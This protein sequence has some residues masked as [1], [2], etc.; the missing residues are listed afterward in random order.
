MQL[1]LA[2]DV[3]TVEDIDGVRVRGG[4]EPPIKPPTVRQ[5]SVPTTIAGGEFSHIAG[6]TDERSR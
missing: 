1:C 4:V 3:S 5:I 6:V 2:N